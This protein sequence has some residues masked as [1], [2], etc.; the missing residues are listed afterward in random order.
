[1]QGD[2]HHVRAAFGPKR[3]KHHSYDE[4][5]DEPPALIDGEA[6]DV[7]RSTPEDE[8][9]SVE[10]IERSDAADAPAFDEEGV[11]RDEPHE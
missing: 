6:V 2:Q 9:E 10:G 3:E 5:V 11:G 7:E 4:G 8:N 1:M